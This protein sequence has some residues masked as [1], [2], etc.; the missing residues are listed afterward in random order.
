MQKLLIQKDQE[1][2]QLRE[3]SESKISAERVEEVQSE[4]YDLHTKNTE[5]EK[6]V[7]DLDACVRALEMKAKSLEKEKQALLININDLNE[8][9]QENQ[10]KYEQDL[11]NQN[12]NITLYTKKLDEVNLI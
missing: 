10:D 7:S 6:E 2:D 11:S 9:I 4:N 12:E 8:E 1:I 5:L 3:E